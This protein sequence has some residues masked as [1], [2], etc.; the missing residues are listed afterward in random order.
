MFDRLRKVRGFEDLG[1]NDKLKDMLIRHEGKRNRPYKDSQ[2]IATIGIGHNIEASPLPPDIAEF[3][4][5]NGRI[6]DEMVFKLL[7]NDVQTAELSCK[8]LYPDFDEF[9]ENRQNAL[10]DFIFNVGEGTALKFKKTNVYIN[11]G[12]WR[13]AA[14]E[15]KN[16]DWY[17]QVQKERSDEIISLIRFG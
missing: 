6:T 15:M 7:D 1:M 2:H 11:N 16:S 4:I 10:I 12:E 3:L 8:R 5:E 17:H 9:T 13:A 14:D